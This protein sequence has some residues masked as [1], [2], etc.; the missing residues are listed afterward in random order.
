MKAVS[1]FIINRDDNKFLYVEKYKLSKKDNRM[2]YLV[3][4]SPR[5]VTTYSDHT[6]HSVHSIDEK[7]SINTFVRKAADN[8]LTELYDEKNIASYNLLSNVYSKTKNDSNVHNPNLRGIK[9]D[10]LLGI[11][12]YN[13]VIGELENFKMSYEEEYS[14]LEENNFYVRQKVKSISSLIPENKMDKEEEILSIPVKELV[15]IKKAA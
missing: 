10:L 9:Q 2:K 7:M 12:I 5:S 4:S 14:L 3:H 1:K 15:R 8:L 13:E 6:F 11:N